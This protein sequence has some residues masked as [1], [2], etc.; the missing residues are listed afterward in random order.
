MPSVDA[1]DRQFP[2]TIACLHDGP[3]FPSGAPFIA[4]QWFSELEEIALGVL[5]SNIEPDD[6]AFRLGSM[7][8]KF[9]TLSMRQ[10]RSQSGIDQAF[11][12]LNLAHVL[13]PGM[14]SLLLKGKDPAGIW[15]T[16][17]GTDIPAGML[18][19]SELPNNRL[20]MSLL[21]ENWFQPRNGEAEVGG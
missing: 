12:G 17:G 5:E 15:W 19:S 6:L 18:L 13:G 20:L 1:A 10:G 3:E 2:L 9:D 11:Y 21:D 4:D 8:S 7:R 14:M 16:E